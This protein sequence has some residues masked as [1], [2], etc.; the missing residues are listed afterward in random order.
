MENS[1]P[2]SSTGLRRTPAKRNT[3]SPKSARKLPL[4]EAIFDAFKGESAIRPK[5][6]GSTPSPSAEI[7]GL[8]EPD[9]NRAAELRP[10]R[11]VHF[12]SDVVNGAKASQ[13]NHARETIDDQEKPLPA[14]PRRPPP[15]TGE[16]RLSTIASVET[17][18]SLS[19]AT[20]T[21]ADTASQ[22]SYTTV[23]QDTVLTRETTSSVSRNSSKPGLKRRLTKHSDLLSVLS[24]PDTT[25]PGRAKSIR[26]ARSVRTARS[27]LETATVQ[28]L[29]RELAEDEAK[30]MRELNTLVDGVIPVLLT[31]VLSKSDSAVAA[32]LFN[33]LANASPT[34]FT[35]PIV[36]M[37]VALER[38]KSLH[39]RIPLTDPDTFLHWAESACKTYEDYLNAWRTG[40]EDVVVNLAPASPSASDLPTDQDEMPR[41]KNGDVVNDNGERVDV[42]HLMKRPHVRVKHLAR[43]IE[44]SKHVQSWS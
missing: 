9:L 30:Y 24:L 22:L 16:H 31:C 14:F 27:R 44:V 6:T 34:S 13:R 8:R 39:K 37:G 25:H 3:T 40:F 21:T 18:S 11:D 26:S 38:L 36:D 29:I 1:P 19:S 2:F 12:E 32:G 41:N 5:S 7:T 23:T 20:E 17:F 43:A 4:K 42:A 28:D 35:K 15:T 10:V 33:P